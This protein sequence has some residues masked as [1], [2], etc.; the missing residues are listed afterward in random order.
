M[1]KIEFTYLSERNLL[2]QLKQRLKGLLSWCVAGSIWRPSE[3]HWS[4]VRVSVEQG[5]FNSCPCGFGLRAV[6]SFCQYLQLEVSPIFM[7]FAQDH[8]YNAENHQ[9]HNFLETMLASMREDYWLVK[10]SLFRKVNCK[11]RKK[12]CQW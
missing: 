5:K 9:K 2:K 7:P 10:A 8:W 11:K 3:P 6:F 4:R 1:D 12:R